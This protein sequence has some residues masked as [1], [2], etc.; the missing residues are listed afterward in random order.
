MNKKILSIALLAVIGTVATGCQKETFTNPQSSIADNC[1]IYTVQ[2][3]VD[4][5]S[6]TSTLYGEDE[7]NAFILQL[8]MMAREGHEVCF[9]NNNIVISSLSKEKLYFS[10][11]DADE[12]TKWAVEKANEGYTVHVDYDE[13]TGM[14]NCVAIK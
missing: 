12:A 11:R 3:T 4:G 10:T 14:Y 7:Y 6:H 8:V 9:S 13:G 1:T 5:V 2:Y